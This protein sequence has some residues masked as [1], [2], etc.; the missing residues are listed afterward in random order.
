[1]GASCSKTCQN[2][3]DAAIENGSTKHKSNSNYCQDGHLLDVHDQKM[4]KLMKQSLEMYTNRTTLDD[5]D[6][7]K[8]QGQGPILSVKIPGLKSKRSNND[9]GESSCGQYHLLFKHQQK[10]IASAGN[11]NNTSRRPSRTSMPHDKENA[12][13]RQHF[14][15]QNDGRQGCEG[16]CIRSSGFESSGKQQLTQSNKYPTR[17]VQ[18]RQAVRPLEEGISGNHIY[19]VRW[20]AGTPLGSGQEG[21]DE[22]DCLEQKYLLG[23]QEQCP[24]YRSTNDRFKMNANSQTSGQY[25][26]TATS[27]SSSLNTK[28]R[29]QQQSKST[30]VAGTGS[31]TTNARGNTPLKNCVKVDASAPPIRKNP[32]SDTPKV[33]SLAADVDD[34]ASTTASVD[35]LFQPSSMCAPPKH[36]GTYFFV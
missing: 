33:L 7:D 12:G 19:A 5:L 1:M 14:R 17:L 26:P 2:F 15:T 27:Q 18:R 32:T 22:D 21:S 29:M 28:Q 23:Q 36:R 35:H 9:I 25:L 6:R 10:G 3:D 16:E 30:S 11:G 20:P 8:E 24:K 34:P 13:E 4:H 31:M